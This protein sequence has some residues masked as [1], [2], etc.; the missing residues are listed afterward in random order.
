MEE[1]LGALG[2]VLNC[3][4]LWNTFCMNAALGQLRA[5]GYPARDEDLARLSQFVRHH[6][7]VHDR[8]SFVLPDLAGGVRPLRDPDADDDRE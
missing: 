5:E 6:L 4:V 8:Y 7:D 1:Q 3:I 2:L